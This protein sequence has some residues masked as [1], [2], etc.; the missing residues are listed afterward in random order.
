M[1]KIFILFCICFFL[2]ISCERPEDKL[3]GTWEYDSF[4]ADE[5]G[6]GF[7]AKF[8]PDDW[9]FTVDEWIENTKGLTNSELSFYPD[10]TYQ[11][12]FSGAA[13]DFTN[14]KG[15]FSVTPDF[16][17][18]RLKYKEMEQAMRL[19]ALTEDYF[20]YKKEFIKYQIPLTLKIKYIRKD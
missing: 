11:E 19:E 1:F 5:S 6:L 18:I 15:H 12:S 16:S 2:F 20:I 10:G 13:K 14:I 7:L 3:V 8:I 4:E 17:E 9:K